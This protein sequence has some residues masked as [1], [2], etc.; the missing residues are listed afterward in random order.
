MKAKKRFRMASV[1]LILILLVTALAAC[2]SQ[3]EPAKT[4]APAPQASSQV[5]TLR[6]AT[7]HPAKIPAVNAGYWIIREFERRSMGRI[8]VEEFYPGTLAGGTQLLQACGKGIVDACLWNP[9]YNPGL[10]P[11]AE[12][13]FVPA[14]IGSTW[15]AIMAFNRSL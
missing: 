4:A 9:S 7:W 6:M 5:I 12:I 10:A 1:C 13:G 3:P 2:S 14:V 15:S 11:L 8:K